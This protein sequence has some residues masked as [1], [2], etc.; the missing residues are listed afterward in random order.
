MVLCYK[1]FGLFWVFALSRDRFNGASG[2]GTLVFFGS[3]FLVEQFTMP[4]QGGKAM[5]EGATKNDLVHQRIIGH[6]FR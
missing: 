2:A 3:L 4:V 5:K 6:A 1:I